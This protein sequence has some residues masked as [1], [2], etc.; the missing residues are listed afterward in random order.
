MDLKSLS[1]HPEQVSSQLP[2]M[3]KLPSSNIQY[4]DEHGNNVEESLFT[5]SEEE[6]QSIE[7]AHANASLVFAP[8]FIPFY[9][10][11]QKEYTLTDTQTKIYGFIRFFMSNQPGKRFYFSDKQI[12]EVANCNPDTAGRSISVLK[13][14]GLISVSWKIKAGGGKIR[15]V[16]YVNRRS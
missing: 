11:V 2:D 12:G 10:N 8:E 5:Y 1:S 9:P 15:F 3:N 13:Q 7:V 16:D 4:Q 14:C 6:K